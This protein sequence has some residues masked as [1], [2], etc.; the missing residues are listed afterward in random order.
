MGYVTGTGCAASVVVG[1]FLSQGGDPLEG[2]AAA[3]AFFGL[4]GEWAARQADAPGSFWVRMLDALYAISPQD[5]ES[6]A[7]IQAA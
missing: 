2:T 7:R 4:A 5:L 6:E 3:L 1:A